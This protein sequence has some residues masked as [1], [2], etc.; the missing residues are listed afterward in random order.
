MNEY[1]QIISKSFTC[2]SV[3]GKRSRGRQ[4]KRWIDDMNGD[5]TLIEKTMFMR[6]RRD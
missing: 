3:D 1:R 2:K 5:M 6:L 4:R